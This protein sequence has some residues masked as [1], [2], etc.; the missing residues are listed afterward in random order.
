L[1]RKKENK[2][3]IKRSRIIQTHCF[4]EVVST[5]TPISK[6]FIINAS[7]AKILIKQEA[8]RKYYLNIEMSM[9][10]KYLASLEVSLNENVKY[11]KLWIILIQYVQKQD[12]HKTLPN[13]HPRYKLK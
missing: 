6:T 12:A 2:E 7:N 13:H 9:K 11:V 5:A 1:K 10:Y 8:I 4:I 3:I